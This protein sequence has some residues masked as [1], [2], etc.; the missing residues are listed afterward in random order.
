MPTRSPGFSIAGPGRRAHRHAHLVADHVG[1]RG[2]AESRRTV[3]QHVIERLAALLRRGDRHLQVLADAILADVLVEQARAQP[4]LVLRV[5]VDARRGHE[6]VVRHL[7]TSRNACFN[8]RS[9]LASDADPMVLIAAS[10]AFSA[11][12]R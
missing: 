7:A 2:L 3:Q 6:A 12:G 5:F 9:K 1:E 10:A 11:R 4:R 8:A